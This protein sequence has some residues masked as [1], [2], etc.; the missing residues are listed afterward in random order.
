MES[1]SCCWLYCDGT[2]RFCLLSAVSVGCN[3]H[4]IVVW[5][6]AGLWS[7]LSHVDDSFT[8][9]LIQV[10]RATS[11]LFVETTAADLVDGGTVDDHYIIAFSD[12][13]CGIFHSLSSVVH[14]KV[15]FSAVVNSRYARWGD[16]HREHAA[17][18]SGMALAGNSHAWIGL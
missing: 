10:S 9:V 15:F 17:T 16:C 5:E 4:V 11:W 14:F 13:H 18:T 1:A 2:H 7:W 8:L 12:C 6:D 3:I